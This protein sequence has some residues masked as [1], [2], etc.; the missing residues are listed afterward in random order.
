MHPF[1][2]KA[3]AEGCDSND[4][5]LKLVVEMTKGDYK[6]NQYAIYAELARMELNS[7]GGEHGNLVEANFRASIQKIYDRKTYC[8]K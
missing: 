3:K 2:E 4:E 5:Y 6:P 1:I 8:K 7:R